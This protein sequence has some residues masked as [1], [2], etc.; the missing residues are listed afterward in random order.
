MDGT[1]EPPL[2]GQPAARATPMPPLFRDRVVIEPAGHEFEPGPSHT[3]GVPGADTECDGWSTAALTLRWAAVRGD[4]HRYYHQPRQ[5]QARAA[6]HRPSGAAVFAVADGVSSA[7]SADVGALDACSAAV[8]EVLH[9]LD[10]GRWPIDAHDVAAAGAG[11]LHHRAA[12]WLG[13]ADPPADRVAKLLATT[14]VAG[15][16]RPG[17]GGV[18]ASL[19][20]IGDSGA[21]ILDRGTGEYRSLFRAKS[22]DVVLSNSV[23]S[24]PHIPRRLDHVTLPLE[25]RLIMLAGTDGFGDPLGDGTG[26]VA[27]HFAGRLAPSP[28]PPLTFAHLLDFSRETYDDDRALLAVWSHPEP[29]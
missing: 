9:Q 2:P 23:S 22:D 4:W 7:E 28:P 15:A 16:V 29:A 27:T 12:Q 18:T 3:P 21:W 24:L 13:V 20:R 14:L 25:P 11:A 17:P 6:V 19:I 1:G 8:A 26:P 5:D 10:R